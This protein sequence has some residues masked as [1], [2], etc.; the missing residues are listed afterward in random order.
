MEAARPNSLTPMNSTVSLVILSP[1][2]HMSQLFTFLLSR[3]SN[4]ATELV[5]TLHARGTHVYLISGGFR[6]MINPV[7][8]ILGINPSR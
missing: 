6:V 3:L 5:S 8:T 4:G 2:P 7:A 1:H